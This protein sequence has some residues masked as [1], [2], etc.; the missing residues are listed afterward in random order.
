[1]TT[2]T[3]ALALAILLTSALAFAQGTYTQIDPPGSIS[4]QCFGIDTA[5]DV[6]GDYEAAD[7][8]LHGFLLRDGTYSTIDY[9]DTVLY[10]IN[11]RNQIVGTS[12]MSL[13]AQGFL[14]NTQTNR[15]TKIVYPG[16]YETQPRAINNAGTT[17]GYFGYHGRSYG[18]ELAESN[19]SEILPPGTLLSNAYGISGSGEIVGQALHRQGDG[20]FSFSDNQG[21]YEVLSLPNVPKGFVNGINPAGTALVGFDEPSGVASAG[22]VYQ[23]GTLTTLEFPGSN[24]TLATGINDL[25]EVVGYF[26]DK[27]NNIHGFTWTPSAPAEKSLSSTK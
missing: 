24:E 7:L 20:Y 4:T 5:G 17:V 1:M 27:N 16:T 11:D 8:H 12:G 6:V 25:G 9:G 19:Y 2:I 23:N 3:R 13:G 15:F 14:Y 26:F 22:F 21:K 18:F 10:G